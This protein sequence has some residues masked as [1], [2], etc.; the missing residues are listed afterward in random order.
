F[1]TFVECS[2]HPVLTM[3]LPDDVV[4]VGSLRRDEGGLDRLL[5]SLAE[6]VVAGVEPDWNAVVPGGHRV[7]LPT[8]P[9][10]HERYWIDAPRGT[11]IP[12][13]H[14]VLAATVDLAQGDG[15][16]L[17]GRIGVGSHPWTADHTL[18]GRVVVPG[19]GM[20]ELALHAADEAGC[21]EV[22]ELLLTTPL[23]LPSHGELDI[24]VTVADPDD[25]GR[26]ALSVHSR[27]AGSHAP[28]TEH[29][30]GVLTPDGADAPATDPVWPP[31]DAEPIPV[32][33][34]TVYAAFADAGFR[35][36]PAFRGLRAA[37]RRGG[38]LFAEIALPDGAVGD[39]DGF[40]VHPA[41]LDAGLHVALLDALDGPGGGLPFAWRGA[42]L[43]ATDPRSL[44]VTLRPAGHDTVSLHFADTTGAP[45]LT[46]ASLV[47]R[48]MTARSLEAAPESLYLPTW[49]PAEAGTRAGTATHAD[50]TV[51]VRPTGATTP[52]D[53]VVD[54]IER[55]RA[56]LA[57]GA[58]RVAVVT[59]R[60]VAARDG[61][62]VLD[63]VHA[64]IPG[65][66]RSVQAEQPGR[67]VLIDSDTDVDTDTAAHASDP[68]LAAALAT[69]EPLVAVRDGEVLVPR[70]DRVTAS[71]SL[72]PPGPMWR[73]EANGPG[74]IDALEAVDHAGDDTEPGP[75][76]VR[77]AVRAAG[78]NFR[79]V[80]IA[81]GMYPERAELGGE[82]AGVVT[83]VGDGVTGFA[84][85]DRVLGMFTGGFGSHAFADARMLAPI[86]E[87][88]TFAE[89]AG[90]P[91]VFLTAYYGLR[92]VAGLEAGESVLVHS[93]AGGVGMAAV[94]LARHWGAT[95]LGTAGPAKWE[96]VRA[97]GVDR[98]ASSR[99][100]GFAEEFAADGP[101]D[102]VLNS[103]AGEFVDASASLLRRGGRF[104]EMGKT[105]VRDGL[106]DVTYRA[107]DLLADAGPDRIGEMLREVLDLFAA[108]ALRH[109]PRRTFD[110]RRARE[111]FRFVGNARHT[112]KVVLTNPAPLDPDGTVLITGGTGTLGALIA[113]HL[114]H[115][116]GMRRLVLAARSAEKATELADEL[117]SAGAHVHL[118]ACD[119]TDRADL[120]ALLDDVPSQHPLT[121]VIHAAGALDDGTLD[122]LTSE[123]VD[124]VL[125][126]KVDAATA[127]HE[128]TRDAD[129]AAFVLF[130]AAGATLGSPGQ[131]NYA[132]ANAY[133]D[134]LAVHRRVQGLPAV[135][136]AW[137]LWDEASGLTA[138]VDRARLGRGGVHPLS[139]AEA[140]GLFDSALRVDEPVVV[141]VGLDLTPR[142]TVPA[143]LRG[144]VRTTAGRRGAATAAES[145]STAQRLAAAAPQQRHRLVL[146]I[147]CDHVAAVL[148]FTHRSAVDEDRPFKDVGFDSLTAVELRNRLSAATGLTLPATLVF[149]HPT[150]TE[151][152][153]HLTT[154]LGPATPATPTGDV[155]ARL[156]G[157]GA[158]LDDAAAT[159]DPGTGDVVAARLRELLDRWTAA[160]G[161]AGGVPGEPGEDPGRALADVADEDIFDFID[162]RF[163]GSDSV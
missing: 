81:L 112:G 50:D 17:T 139:T 31:P 60:A 86:P 121:A 72:V 147:V 150:P 132:A 152:A 107:F 125:P 153:G 14:P 51:V 159:A 46:V 61:E 105:D 102:V 79:D 78:L 96:A 155:L 37:W 62:D 162:Q 55:L 33:A 68:V 42:A 48:T 144:L 3:T 157:M 87:G 133:L 123:R 53:A 137:G 56:A 120:T 103:L 74:T 41:L 32:E 54:V 47:S 158:E 18:Q 36:G 118:A 40:A 146:D 77:I 122:S 73:V 21:A 9:F 23:I 111:A 76:Q 10:Q 145:A 143:I 66:V 25:D 63:L 26:R 75:G 138:H 28:W 64:P 135:S 114:V 136:L 113:R 116:H 92:D 141:P 69:G 161:A 12:G 24:Q 88:W 117:R 160:T 127:L 106:P 57:D 89:A 5:L 134:A 44:R 43:H 129:L 154:E 104:V 128:L 124:A 148:G 93:A 1:G 109:L 29:A 45:V 52:R 2:P 15:L 156:D 27:Q 151:L 115:A 71:A 4:A 110:T 65:L 34:D 163:G 6:A 80:M 82:G 13:R 20:L 35:Y 95:V 8:Y 101:V 22:E 7:D 100:L 99:D 16:V 19:T 84:P 97:L 90:V 70:L 58:A 140:V 38:E 142:E 91:V 39:A 149:D 126:V 83:A 59:T 131:G 98:L 119:V 30:T 108:G 49:I 67:V 85:G 11:S 94:Q 130:S